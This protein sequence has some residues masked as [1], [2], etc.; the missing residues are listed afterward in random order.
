LPSGTRRAIK[1]DKKVGFLQ[2]DTNNLILD[3]VLTDKGREFLSR[4]DGSFSVIKFAPGDDEV[5]YTLIQKF[6]RT[7]GK[8]KIE[9]NTP[10]FEALTNGNLSQ[11]YRL[12]SVSNP[13]LIR[14]PTLTFTGESVDSVNKLVQMGV[15]TNKQK[16]L[17][18][19]QTITNENSIDVELRDSSFIVEMSNLFLQIPGA[20]APD[21]ID[22][23][24]RASYI[25]VR[26]AES[27]DLGGSKLT[28]SLASKAITPSQFAIYGSIANKNV[29]STFVKVYGVLSGAVIEF[30]VQI[31]Q[32]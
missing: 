17:T 19:S 7:V 9:K 12:V 31:S 5:D 30:E 16:Q 32:V 24:Q 22:S 2:G 15:T 14:L 1:K 26:N 21:N 3:A 29:I 28:F 20:N 11:K 4:N 27:T 8:E 10:I 18:V 13:N 23:Q 25:L 6:G